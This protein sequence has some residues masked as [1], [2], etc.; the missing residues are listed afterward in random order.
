MDQ[1]ERGIGL[2]CEKFPGNPKPAT[3]FPE[4]QRPANF[5]PVKDEKC[6]GE[7]EIQFSDP[8]VDFPEATIET[9]TMQ[10]IEPDSALVENTPAIEFDDLLVGN[11][12]A[13]GSDNTFVM[14]KPRDAAPGDPAA[15]DTAD[16]FPDAP[17]KLRARAKK[18]MMGRKRDR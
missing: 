6:G 2:E 11:I 14:N 18:D 4:R 12:P 10:A 16:L 7:S 13:T 1:P 17:A 8:A 9:D 15:D 3:A 5:C